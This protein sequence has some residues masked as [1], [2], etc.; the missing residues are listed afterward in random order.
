[1]TRPATRQV[2]LLLAGLSHV[3]ADADRHVPA[4][5]ALLA[6]ADALAALPPGI[7]ERLFR[8]FGIAIPEG[9][10]LPI[11]A[12]TRLADMGVV[13]RE[14]W[15]RADPVY[16]EP[17][18]DSLVLHPVQLTPSEATELVDEVSDSLVPDG[19]LLRAP[20]PQR[21]Y[22]KPPQAP[23]LVTTPL[24]DAVGRDIRELL[25]RGLDGKAWHTRLSELQILLHTARA[26]AAREGRGERPAN[27]VWFWGGGRL[28]PPAT[29]PWNQVW[30]D[31]P[32]ALGLARLCAV[33]A[34]PL[35]ADAGQWLAALPDGKQLLV[36][37]VHHPARTLDALNE[38]WIAPLRRAVA[39]GR[40]T[41][42]HVLADDGPQ[43]CCRR[44]QRLRFWRRPRPLA[45][46]FST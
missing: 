35:P 26:N 34:G 23:T 44:A 30:S 3:G 14:W 32:L 11:A 8:L 24:A 1:M 40:L 17:G 36:V 37:D 2:T 12:V 9:Q 20:H 28:P 31:E 33:P 7:E 29:A 13:D 18:R 25:P 5:A 43:Y 21:W 4:L 41:E 16:L 10:D 6:R 27:S 22:A 45:E 39:N 38:Q 46:C 42:L 15:I 19:W